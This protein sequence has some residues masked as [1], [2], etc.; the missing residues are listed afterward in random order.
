MIGRTLK[1][2][3]KLAPRL[4][5]YRRIRRKLL[6]DEKVNESLV[7]NEAKK[8]V[9]TLID[10]G[11]TFVKLGQILSVRS[12][13]FPQEYLEELGKLQDEVPPS[14]FNEILKI[15]R[16]ELGRDDI[17]IEE[18]PIGSASLGQVHKGFFRGRD[19]AIKVNRPNVKEILETDIRILKR[20][21]PLFKLI[22]DKNLIEN[23]KTVLE[24]FSIKVFEEIDYTK[25]AFYMKKIKE[26][27]EGYPIIIPNV[28]FYTKR[29]LIMEYIPGY[30]ITSNE[31]KLIVNNKLLAQRVFRLY[32]T[33]LLKKNYFHADPHP[34]NLAVDNKGNLILYDY[35][36]VDKIDDKTRRLLIRAY[37]AITSLNAEELVRTLD[38]LGAIDPF[39]NRRLLTKGIELFLR[40]FA[41]YEVNYNEIMDFLNIANKV[42]YRFPLRL[43]SKLVYALRTL[44][45]LE[46]TCRLIDPDFNLFESMR[47]YMKYESMNNE[48]LIIRIRTILDNFIN[49]IFKRD[50]ERAEMI[51]NE[52]NKYIYISYF[53]LIFSVIIYLISKDLILTL[54]IIIISIV[55]AIRS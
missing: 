33:M 38:E 2:V 30:K 29:V 44:M 31:A 6:R 24:E 52:N 3:F 8:F 36:M 22:L 50:N 28:L 41:G 14:P 11:P 27:L 12:D 43:P 53:L 16:E 23:F 35:G 48:F 17:L 46:G 20:L 51:K 4:W 55:I 19:V 39:A 32:M 37:F 21:I 15:I 18:K 42:F 45:V 5:N 49:I 25:E 13:I 54:I 7:R 26:E 10:L 34:G 1:I 40:E 47:D 9:K